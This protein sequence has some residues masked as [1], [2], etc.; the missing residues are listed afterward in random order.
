M[1]GMKVTPLILALL[2]LSGSSCA[3]N[4]PLS[5]ASTKPAPKATA[6]PNSN[7]LQSLHVRLE[8][9]PDDGSVTYLGWYDG[10]R[11]LLG[12]GGIMTAL[13]GMEPPE[14]RGEL[15][16]LN[17]SELVY[18]GLDQNGIAWSKRY[19]LVE[20]T[21]RVTHRITSRRDQPFDAIV[22][23]LADLPDA[24]ITGDNRDQHITTPI[25]SAHF[26]ATIANAD[27][28]GESMNPYA[29]RSDTHRLEPGESATFEMTWELMP[30][31]AR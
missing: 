12:P 30:E 6:K 16:R 13:V 21:V 29:L 25:A 15:K 24:T 22:Y 26:H 5:T 9:N 28:P 4:N 31:R 18:E 10:N 27:F 3:P 7:I 2:F 20:N 1:T 11:N 14:L 19:R 17:D 23:S 8:I